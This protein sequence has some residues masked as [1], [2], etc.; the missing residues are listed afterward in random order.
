MVRLLAR[1]LQSSRVTVPSARSAFFR[2]YS[3]ASSNNNTR[4]ASLGPKPANIPDEYQPGS[5]LGVEPSERNPHA[6]DQP[7]I[8]PRGLKIPTSST[9]YIS[10][11]HML[12]RDGCKCQQ[13]VDRYSKQRKFRQSDIPQDIKPRSADWD[14]QTLKVKWENDVPGFDDTHTSV[15]TYKDLKH[16]CVNYPNS[17]TGRRRRRRYW[18][19]KF[20][21]YWIPYEDY[22]L[23]DNAFV[24]AMRHLAGTGLLFIKDAPELRDIAELIA[25]RMGPLRNTFYGPT[26]DVRSEHRAKNV[27]YTDQD[28]G[29]HM[30]LMYMNEPPGYQILHC[31]KNSCEGGESLFADTFAVAEQLRKE[32]PRAF[33][34][35]CDLRIPYEYNHADHIYS[36][37]WPVIQ[38]YEDEDTNEIRLVRT[39]YSPPFQA[40][41]YGQHRPFDQTLAQFAAL[42]KFA[43]MLES[44]KFVCELKLN[45]GEAVIFENRRVVHARRQFNTEAGERWLA[46]AYVDEDAVLSKF[47][48][49]SLKCPD[50][51]YTDMKE[52]YINMQEWHPRSSGADQNEADMGRTE[53]DKQRVEAH[54]SRYSEDEQDTQKYAFKNPRKKNMATMTKRELRRAQKTARRKRRSSS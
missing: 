16:P 50:M 9:A 3:F 33:E 29:F 4:D 28:L 7:V 13:C 38:T 6:V 22:M 32:D 18:G 48:T 27:A 10:T 12:L 19:G 36:N 52:W 11:M 51:W 14:G 42:D 23:D 15:Y 37:T 17:S 54:R 49:S 25:T 43:K 20:T 40:P 1:F 34:T 30:D 44:K 8:G 5:T 46:G 41:V 35:L 24:R 31:L 47:V 53:A 45:P 26:W 2:G 21:H 39:N